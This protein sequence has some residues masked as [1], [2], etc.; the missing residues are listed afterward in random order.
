MHLMYYIDNKGERVYTLAKVKDG[1]V[2][3]P[4]SSSPNHHEAR[5][6]G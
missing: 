5:T 4:R 2:S 3:A 6:R 1:R